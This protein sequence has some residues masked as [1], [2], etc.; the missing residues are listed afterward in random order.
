MGGSSRQTAT[1][2]TVLATSSKETDSAESELSRD[3]V[4]V[5]ARVGIEIRLPDSRLSLVPGVGHVPPLATGGLPAL[6]LDRHAGLA[7][8]IVIRLRGTLV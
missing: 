2:R 3:Q 4:A 8:K 1:G 7:P 5:A 6:D